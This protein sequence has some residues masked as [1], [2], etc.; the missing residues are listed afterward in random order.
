MIQYGPRTSTDRILRA[1][2]A[3]AVLLGAFFVAMFLL[4]Q[5]THV[6]PGTASFSNWF[7][8][9]TNSFLCPVSFSIAVLALGRY[10]VLRDPVSYWTG[11]GFVVAGVGLFYWILARPGILPAGQTFIGNS[12]S[13]PPRIAVSWF[14]IFGLCLL[15]GVV[16][17]RP[18]DLDLSGWR[19][20]SSVLFWILLMTLI[21]VAAVVW[22][23]SLP[24]LVDEPGVFTPIYKMWV[25]GVGLVYG[26]GAVLSVRH[27]RRTGDAL[28][29]YVTFVQVSI[30]FMQVMLVVG[31]Q[32]Y[33][34]LFLGSRLLL[35]GSFLTVL[36]GLLSGYVELFRREQEKARQLTARSAELLSILESIPVGVFVTD[37]SGAVRVASRSGMQMLGATS[38][39]QIR[40]SQ[41][42]RTSERDSSQSGGGPAEDLPLARV[43]CGEVIRNEEVQ[44]LTQAGDKRTWALLSGGPIADDK[45]GPLGGLL[46][47]TDISERKATEETVVQLNRD[48][49]R[50]VKELE[51]VLREK[52]LLLK[53]VQHRVK[54]NLQVISSL[55]S[56]QAEHAG[57][58]GP[59]RHAMLT[60]RDRV[61]SMS[62][63]H[64]SL[65]FSGVL[66]EI[67][68]SKYIESLAPRLVYSYAAA[69][70]EIRLHTDVNATLRLDEATPCGLIVNELLSNALK[71]A[72]P[73]SRG[74]DIWITFR[75]AHDEFCL[76]IRDNGVGLPPGFSVETSD[77]LGLQVV[78]ELTAQL[79]GKL[80]WANEN[81]AVFRVQ[82]CRRPEQAA[83][84]SAQANV[85][86]PPKETL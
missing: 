66:A 3:W 17:G 1:S 64:E 55:A 19:W 81:G 76:E 34:Y 43:A 15:A 54:N 72:F 84:G 74:G 85:A 83:S 10:R 60:M 61:K 25:A 46:I 6:I 69:P 2:I 82:F 78:T 73:D 20:P 21:S 31:G 65:C 9:L 49:D 26:V 33:G 59:A 57:S 18:R 36:I 8:P 30:T 16:F 13:T 11:V 23:D 50:H 37:E 28:L 47:A 52:S 24:A 12:L 7:V 79:H 58:N 41:V 71:Y 39:E 51:S 80:S 62:L 44:I 38:S 4:G 32:R 42:E 22:E 86:S 56:L 14:T 67:D 35:I 63:I 53:E 77:S 45:G 27:Y 48:L 29:G 75:Q 5:A 40:A 70:N 68:F